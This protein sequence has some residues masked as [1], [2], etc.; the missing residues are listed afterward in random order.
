MDSQCFKRVIVPCY[1]RMTTT[2]LRMLNGDKELAYDV[3]QDTIAALWERREAINI[4]GSPEALCVTA[5]RNRCI[6]LLRS[7]KR[8]SSIEEHPADCAIE[9]PSDTDRVYMA[10]HKLPAR[11]KKVIVMSMRGFS[12]DEIASAMSTLQKM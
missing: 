6:S 7:E 1:A 11:H 12:N 4:S 9:P 3:V 5:V 8:M 2:A 10:I